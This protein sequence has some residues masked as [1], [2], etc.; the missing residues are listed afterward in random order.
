MKANDKNFILPSLKVN[1]PKA[2]TIVAN[3]SL[4]PIAPTIGI[5]KTGNTSSLSKKNSMLRNETTTDSLLENSDEINTFSNIVILSQEIREII[6]QEQKIEISFKKLMNS[7]KILYS[8]QQT[9]VSKINYCDLKAL[10]KK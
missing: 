7:M 3:S 4:T 5:F 9:A 2:P 1:I 10:F 8:K 6:R